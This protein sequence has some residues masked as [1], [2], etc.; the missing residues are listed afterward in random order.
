MI[1]FC[2][3]VKER[4]TV[5][6]DGQ[7]LHLFPNCINALRKT[8]VSLGLDCEFVVA[9]WNSKDW[10]LDMW[11][12][13][14]AAPIPVKIV[15]GTG[16]FSRGKGRNLA[17][18]NAS[19]DVIAFIDADMLVD[20]D[21][22]THGLSDVRSGCASFPLYTA[23]TKNGLTTDGDGTGNCFLS[24]EVASK[25]RWPERF[26]WGQEDRMY[27]DEVGKICRVVRRKERGLVHQWHPDSVQW[28]DRFVPLIP[29]VMHSIWI[30]PKPKP[31]RWIDSWKAKNPDYEHAM[32]DADRIEAEKLD[33]AEVIKKIPTWNGKTNVIR[34]E[35][36]YRYGGVVP[37]A[38][39]EALRP[40]PEEVLQH[41]IIACWENEE[42]RPGLVG[43]AIVGAQPNH[44]IFPPI[45]EE[46]KKLTV[47]D[48]SWIKLGP[49]L[50]TRHLVQ[51]FAYKP[52]IYPAWMFNP[53]HFTGHRYD[54]TDAICRH[55]WGTTTAAYKA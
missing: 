4:S 6:A 7:K 12:R 24:R 25:V 38:D 26:K 34:Y 41:P 2:F 13:S 16:Q 28:K 3:V 1:S 11:I 18:D 20:A 39:T 35:L 44:P 42:M 22:V 8:V 52:K 40:L 48:P 23:L 49:L 19:G 10:P 32:W 15:Q 21:V 46:I 36:L 47:F 5:I 29:R 37:D 45:L 27:F 9:D 31:D 14:A 54:A 55:Y 30:G 50:W 33:C 17:F 53:E 51:N 43:F